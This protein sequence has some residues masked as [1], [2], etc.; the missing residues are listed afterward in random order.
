MKGVKGLM[1]I[2]AAKDILLASKITN[3]EEV[4]IVLK[5]VELLWNAQH[6]SAETNELY[7]LMD[8]IFIYKGIIWG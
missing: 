2:L 5:S 3:K 6:I 7:Q 1:T 4:A 8:F